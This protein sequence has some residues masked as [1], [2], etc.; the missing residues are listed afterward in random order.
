MKAKKPIALILALVIV[1]AVALT[2]CGSQSAQPATAAN[3]D[4]PITLKF[5]YYL[6]AGTLYE[7]KCVDPFIKLVEERS[8]GTIKIEKY[9]GGTL[10]A[11]D[12]TLDA[13]K[14]GLADIGWL[15]TGNYTGSLPLTFMIEYPTYWASA[16]AASYALRDYINE[17]QPA[18]Y[19]GLHVVMGFCS[20]EGILINNKHE[21]RK[22][23]DLKGMEIR[24][25]GVM[26]EVITAFGGTPVSM[27][28]SEAYEA[29][30]SGVVEGYM[31]TP[32]SVNTLKLFEVTNN[33]TRV[34]FC[35]TSHMTI[36]NKK[37]YESMSENQRKIFDECAEEVFETSAC[38]WF[39]AAA[40]TTYKAIANAGG[41]IVYLTKEEEQPFLDKTE[42]LMG[43]YA[44]KLDQQGLEGTKA[45][46]LLLSLRDKYNKMY[47]DSAN[48][49]VPGS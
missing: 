35:N 1:C 33:A 27:V 16:K 46:E 11:A 23:D 45:M 37:V 31:A 19:D 43:D 21:I 14:N 6:N 40:P 30:R 41:K 15:Y 49:Y 24:V 39:E 18:E 17:L 2:G 25:N 26:S 36:M 10:C 8:N 20:G 5:A 42:G 3:G 32:E 44:K 4:K 7:Q 9:P 12:A 34:H 48:T 13:V 22:P 28:S 47:P 29:L 38:D